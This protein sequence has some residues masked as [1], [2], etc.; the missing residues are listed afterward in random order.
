[1]EEICHPAWPLRLSMAFPPQLEGRLEKRDSEYV[2]AAWIRACLRLSTKL[3]PDAKALSLGE[4]VQASVPRSGKP[5]ITR[6]PG[7]G[8]ATRKA[9]KNF[10]GR[11]CPEPLTLFR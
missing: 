7:T 10:R 11:P 3:N 9:K 6:G 1:M 4:C 8:S 2:Y 5:K